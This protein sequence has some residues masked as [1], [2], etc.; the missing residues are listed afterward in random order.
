MIDWNTQREGALHQTADQTV[1]NG[2]YVKCLQNVDI[3]VHATTVNVVNRSE[4]F[5]NQVNVVL[6]TYELKDM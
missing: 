3:R 5:S 2:I 1:A 6:K 4:N